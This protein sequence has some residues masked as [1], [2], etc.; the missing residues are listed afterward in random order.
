MG[1]STSKGRESGL[2]Q[3]GGTVRRRHR[4]TLLVIAGV[5][6]ALRL[7]VVFAAL[8]SG[9]YAQPDDYF[10]MG[11]AFL[12]TGD[13]SWVVFPP[14]YPVLCGLAQAAHPSAG[15]VALLFVQAALGG[16]LVL[17]VY[18]YAA[19]AIGQA[20]ATVAAALV[21]IDPS[22]VV[23]AGLVL[24]EGLYTLL[25]VL[26]T[27][28]ML[29]AFRDRDHPGIGASAVAGVSVGLTVLTRAVGLAAC[30]TLLLAAAL[31]GWTS[32]ARVRF[33]RCGVAATIAIAV[34]LPWSYLNLRDYG[35][36]LPTCS[37]DYNVAA[38]WVGIARSQ[39]LGRQPEGSI[40]VWRDD[41]GD[42]WDDPNPFRR[43]REAKRA[44]IAWAAKNHSLVLRCLL[45][46]QVR[47]WVAPWR[48]AW[49][50]ITGRDLP[51]AVAAALI[52]WRVTV[53][54]LAILG[55]YLTVTRG[56][57]SS[58]FWWT[59]GL[60][61]VVHTASVGCAGYGRFLVPAIP[62]AA[63]FA[64]VGAARAALMWQNRSAVLL[65]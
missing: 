57:R 55:A 47:L 15:V 61:L 6:V 46:S 38:L 40:A 50:G 20:K 10:A 59:S 2:D 49:S 48:G 5:A 58:A 19:P 24:T 37:G 3:G 18:G 31:P 64:S 36:V 53:L 16:A 27:S 26:T 30:V 23:S 7:V 33:L 65:R 4:V 39:E 43:S 34:V 25:M 28:L 44:A 41:M 11:H 29:R 22:S 8:S 42:A 1:S 63:L 54:G 60:L 17:C 32:P 21:A 45:W 35:S 12:T 9:G 56:D 13:R 62:F 51:T 14:L 52:I